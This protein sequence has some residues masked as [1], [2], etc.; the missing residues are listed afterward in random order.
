M[1]EKER[2]IEY[3]NTP[4]E[5]CNFDDYDYTTLNNIPVDM[6]RGNKKTKLN[7]CFIMLDTETSKSKQDVYRM[8]KSGKRLKREYDENRNYIVKWSIAINVYGFNI[9]CLW[10]SRP[11]DAVNTI[12]KII[13]NMG[14]NY[15]RIYVANLSYDYTFL[16]KFFFSTWGTPAAMLA[17]K[18]H[19]PISIQFQNGVELR[20]SLILSQRSIEKWGEDLDVA[21]KKAVGKW[22]YKKIRNQ[23]DDITD[24]ELLYI[25]NDVLCG[26]ECLDATRRTLGK[27]VRGIPLTATGIPRGE[28]RTIGTKHN[29]H[30]RA[31]QLY[32]DYAQYLR[33]E[34][35]YHGGYTHANRN[36]NGWTINNVVCYDFASKYPACL[37]AYK[38]PMEKFTPLGYDPAPEELLQGAE[39]EAYIF[40]AEFTNIRLKNYWFPMPALQLSKVEN[41]VDPVTDN[42]RILEAAS[43]KI[44]LT[45]IDFEIIYKY[46][47][48]DDCKIT[49][50]EFA[51][52]DYLPRWI[53]DYI[54]KIFQEKTMYKGGD[55]VIYAIK[56]AKLNCIYGTMVQKLLHTIITENYETGEYIVEQPNSEEE[57]NKALKRRG[58]FLFYPWGLYVTAYAMR[59]LFRLGECAASPEDWIY[60]DTDSCYFAGVD[61][62]KINDY[63]KNM[64]ETLSG[65]G[66][67]GVE[68]NGRLYWL[69]VAELDG[70]YS[71]FRAHHSKCYAARDAETG[72]LKITVAGVPKKN[73]AKC[74]K[75]DMENFKP[76]FIFD[77][78]TTG[79]LTHVYQYVDEI[80]IDE[81][82]N[83]VADS[84]N[85]IPCDYLTSPTIEQKIDDIFTEEIEVQVFDD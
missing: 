54:Y 20:D 32:C 42:G 68:H 36:V 7:E 39:D 64:I 59:D 35:V 19:Y 55:P 41:V 16:R 49:N 23:K 17:T 67:P 15:T 8:V 61:E 45:E 4:F 14:G 65:R 25:C 24:D 12:E 26:V 6:P 1:N 63:N 9:V 74:L 82:G 62:N 22:E 34:R 79:K 31:K 28:L 44:T 47:D 5:I 80:Y 70:R 58:L 48:F 29:A 60:S 46:Y 21:H 37:L 10:G 78:E 76:G 27:T 66:Y 72:I 13:N 81:N 38:F 30:D 51:A 71:E 77:G 3:F 75:D 18:P 53:T 83:E 73:G 43:C 50:C 2:V 84:V 56:K 11:T 52:K 57:Y 33:F 40:D 85:L 69:G